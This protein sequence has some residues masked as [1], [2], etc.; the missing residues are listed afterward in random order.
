M[1]SLN[2][3]NVLVERSNKIIYREGDKLYKTFD[4]S[5]SKSNVLNE[6]LNQ[7]RIEETGLKIPKVIEVSIVN[8]R[9]TI[10]MEFIEGVTLEKLM[11][12]NPDKIDEYLDLFVNL[13]L[14]LL[15][16]SV[17]LLNRIKDKFRRKLREA[18]NI[19]DELNQNPS[20]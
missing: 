8:G 2:K 16:K 20:Y 6:G 1:S 15:S 10:I 12:E 19:D 13:Q 5:Y 18:T 17:P 11:Q 14:E 9:C 4:E 3:V 7:A